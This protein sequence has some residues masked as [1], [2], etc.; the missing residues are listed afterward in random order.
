MAEKRGGDFGAS[1]VASGDLSG[2]QFRMVTYGGAD[3]R[4]WINTTSAG[5]VAGV[6]QNK[7]KHLEHAA[8]IDMG[9]TKL[10]L[11]GS[12]AGNAE[13][14]SNNAGFAIPVSSGGVVLGRLHSAGDS[15]HIV[16]AIVN[17]AGYTKQL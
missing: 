16:E 6:L 17:A 14:M 3:N 5:I 10:Q 13:F 11:G 12:M 7:P 2:S 9:H 1:W 15:G 4:V 8:V